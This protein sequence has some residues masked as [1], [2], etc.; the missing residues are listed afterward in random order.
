VTLTLDNT[1]SMVAV[2]WQATNIDTISGGAPW[3]SISPPSDTVL[4]GTTES[5]IVTPDPTLCQSSQPHGKSWHIDITTTTANVGPFNF[6]Y[7]VA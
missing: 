1:Q 5:V 6:T 2:T 7:N 3:A 4:A